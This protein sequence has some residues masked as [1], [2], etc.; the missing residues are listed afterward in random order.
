MLPQADL[1]TG[2]QL[3]SGRQ[4]FGWALL[5]AGAVGLL[6]PVVPGLPL[7]IAGAAVLG[8][9]HP[10]VRTW[11]ARIDGWRNKGDKAG[12]SP[13]YGQ[14]ADGGKSGTA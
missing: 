9:E 14:P 10:V 8:P 11:K 2:S 7:L 1:Y 12:E 4:V 5:I 6:L 13:Q 3:S